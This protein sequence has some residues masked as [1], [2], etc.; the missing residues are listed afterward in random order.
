MFDGPAAS[1]RI[2]IDLLKLVQNPKTKVPFSG[3][4]P[5]KKQV[6][7]VTENIGKEEV[8]YLLDCATRSISLR[9]AMPALFMSLFDA[10][11]NSSARVSW[12]LRGLFM[13]PARAPSL[14]WRMARSI[15]RCGATSTDK[16]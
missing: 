15:L 13:L 4:C 9:L 8:V 7:L 16:W 2:H 11:T 14:M 5:V 12:M 3:I 6:F 10:N 1:Q